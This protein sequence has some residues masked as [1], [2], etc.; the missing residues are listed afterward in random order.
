MLNVKC[1]MSNLSF[2]RKNQENSEVKIIGKF[3]YISPSILG[4]SVFGGN[5]VSQ[6]YFVGAQGIVLLILPQVFEFYSNTT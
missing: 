1:Q 3:E 2:F 5:S 6:A 4:G